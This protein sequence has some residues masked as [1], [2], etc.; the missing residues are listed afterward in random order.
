MRIRIEEVTKQGLSEANDE[1]LRTLRFQFAKFWDNHFK[2]NSRKVVGCFTRNNFVAKYRL[3]LKEMDSSRRS[4]EHSTCDIDRKAFA[5]S[6]ETKQAGIDIAQLAQ[7]VTGE[8]CI[9]LDK[10]FAQADELKITIQQAADGPDEQLEKDLT[11]M[12]GEQFDKPC[13][14]VYEQ[15]F[16]GEGIPLFHE[17][18]QPVE[19]I[20]KIE[21]ESEEGEG[22]EIEKDI[23]IIPIEKGDE[24]IVYGIVYEPDTKDAQ[25]DQASAEEIKKA[26]YNFME[27]VQT[28]KVMHKGNKVKIKILEN[29]IAPV[30]FTIEKR[31][32]KEGSWVLVTRILDKQVWKDIKAGK[33]TGYSMA[34][35]A[36]VDTE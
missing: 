16:K 29:Y 2:H 22:E 3:L 8:N 11:K 6:M 12:L 17:V 14:F 26:A 13:A 24:H 20:E 36:K 34:G 1:E 15:N 23:E 7:L 21:L 9:I 32:V 30:D 18:L 31:N 25:G 19:K 5:Q 35:Y 4:L 33:L 10:D 27:H 28:F